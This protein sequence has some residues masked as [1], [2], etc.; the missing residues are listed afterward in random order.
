M[1]ARNWYTPLKRY[2][3]SAFG[4][5]KSFLLYELRGGSWQ[6]EPLKQALKDV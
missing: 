3:E 1:Q 6:Q 5:R 2:S 4:V